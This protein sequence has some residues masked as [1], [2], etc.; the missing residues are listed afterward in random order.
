MMANLPLA[1]IGGVEAVFAGGGVLSVA[2]LDCISQKPEKA[3]QIQACLFDDVGE[4]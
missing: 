4:R 3:V 2:S 1:L